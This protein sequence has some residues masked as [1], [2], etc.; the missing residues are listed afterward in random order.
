MDVNL[1]KS[2]LRNLAV[3]LIDMQEYSIGTREE[4]KIISSQVKVLKFCRKNNI[5]VIIAEYI[6]KGET[7]PRL[8]RKARKLPANNFY[9]IIKEYDSVFTETRVEEIL[10]SWQ[11]QYLLVTGIKACACVHQTVSEAVDKGF[12]VITANDLIAGYCNNCS[13]GREESWYRST[14]A[15][16]DSYKQILRQVTS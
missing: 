14:V 12:K 1:N 9:K 6:G 16:F 15:Y 13:Q 2:I 8:L 4:R 5:P 10:E 11:I 7:L 3:V